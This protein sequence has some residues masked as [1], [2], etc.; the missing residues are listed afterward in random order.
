MAI[1]KIYIDFENEET[2]EKIPLSFDLKHSKTNYLWD[3]FGLTTKDF[4][5]FEHIVDK[6][7]YSCLDKEFKS[8]YNINEF[9][10][11]LDTVTL[12]ELHDA[13]NELIKLAF[14]KLYKEELEKLEKEKGISDK[15]EPLEEEIEKKQ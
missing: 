8:K 15:E 7:L 14:P 2:G 11:L 10:E 12:E 9:V 3:K 4:A 6:I 1:K 5:R 13:I